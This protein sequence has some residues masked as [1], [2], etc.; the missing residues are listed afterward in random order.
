LKGGAIILSVAIA[1]GIALLQSTV[2]DFISIV[3]VH[4]D[5]VLIVVVFVAHR[6][7]SM[8]G[9]LAGLGSGVALDLMGN[10]PLGLY[11]LIYTVVGSVFGITRGKMFVDP[12]FMPVLFAVVGLLLKALIGVVIAG[13]FGID[14]I[15]DTLFSASYAF[16]IGYTAFVCPVVFALLRLVGPLQPERRRGES[17]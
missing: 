6:N 2:L 14:G 17:L 8:F 3:G 4:P 11:A 15:S 1:G 13:L 7:G 10:S 9:Q 5:L 12:V 16:E